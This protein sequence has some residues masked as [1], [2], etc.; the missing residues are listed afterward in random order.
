MTTHKTNNTIRQTLHIAAYSESDDIDY[1][2]FRQEAHEEAPDL[3]PEFKV[4][5]LPQFREAIRNPAVRRVYIARLGVDIVGHIAFKLDRDHTTVKLISFYM[6][7]EYRHKGIG[8]RLYKK[9]TDFASEMNAGL[10]THAA[11]LGNDLVH[12]FFT[13]IKDWDA[14]PDVEYDDLVHYQLLTAA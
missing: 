6:L 10:I 3:M 9:L 14:I 1:L 5:D 8:G 4:Q 2:C 12:S 11:R 7:A 13:K